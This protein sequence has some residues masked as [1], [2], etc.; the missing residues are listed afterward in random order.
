MDTL[1]YIPPLGWIHWDTYL[2]WDRCPRLV[3]LPKRFTAATHAEVATSTFH[4]NSPRSHVCPFSPQLR[5]AG[6][7]RDAWVG[8]L[9]ETVKVLVE[10][11]CGESLRYSTW[12]QVWPPSPAA[13]ISHQPSSH[14][15][16]T[17]HSSFITHHSS[18]IIDTH[19]SSLATRHLSFSSHQPHFLA[20]MLCLYPA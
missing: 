1:G 19:P 12:L 15:A 2:L 20:I 9:S 8:L 18:F 17:H 10:E 13:C 14:Q 11:V 4:S 5:R 16:I 3:L 7:L 6:A